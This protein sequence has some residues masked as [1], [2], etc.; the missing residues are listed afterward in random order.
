MASS[1]GDAWGSAWGDSWGKRVTDQADFGGGAK[2]PPE[3]IEIDNKTF[4]EIV[5]ILLLSGLL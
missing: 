2:R 3:R 1:W 4:T 5:E